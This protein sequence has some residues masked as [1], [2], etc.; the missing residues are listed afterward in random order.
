MRLLR[1]AIVTGALAS[2]VVAACS[3]STDP[4]PP[5]IDGDWLAVSVNEDEFPRAVRCGLGGCTYVSEMQ[6]RFRTRGRVLDLRRFFDD[7]DGEPP[8]E[9]Y[10]YGDAFPYQ[11]IGRDSF[12]IV[13]PFVDTAYADT[14]YFAGDTLVLNVRKLDQQFGGI[15][16]GRGPAVRYLRREEATP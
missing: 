8:G 11:V 1:A 12:R 16:T 13:R 6:L 5:E 10:D 15:G 9:P 7:F 2:L 4:G 14:G 3:D